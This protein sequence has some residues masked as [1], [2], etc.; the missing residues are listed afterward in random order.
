MAVSPKVVGFDD[1]NDTGIYLS[2][3]SIDVA[4]GYTIAIVFK[5]AST[6]TGYDT[7]LCA[8]NAAHSTNVANIETADVSGYRLAGGQ[9]GYFGEYAAAL[10]TLTDS[11][12]YLGVLGKNSGSSLLRLSLYTFSTD[13][14]QHGNNAS[15]KGDPGLSAAGALIGSYPGATDRL[16]GWFAAGAIWGD[17]LSDANRETLSDNLDAWTAL[18]PQ[19]MW[20]ANGSTAL[21]DEIG[22]ADE[23]S[24]GAGVSDA[25]GSQTSPID[26]AVTRKPQMTLLGAG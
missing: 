5:L 11:A 12:W 23:T 4:T 14:W 18:S 25:S 20:V 6:H 3:G 26:W 2:G 1:A 7:L 22:S 19:A 21:V 17:N 16:E 10:D 15:A 8:T 13:T 24:R 9:D